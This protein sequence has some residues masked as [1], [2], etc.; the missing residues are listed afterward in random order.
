MRINI[1]YFKNM[2]ISYEIGFIAGKTYFGNQI[3][4]K[5][6]YKQYVPGKVLLVKLLE[7]YAEKGIEKIDFGSGDNHIK[8]AFTK[9]HN[10][11]YQVV[12]SANTFVRVY[13]PFLFQVKNEL[14]YK[15]QE[16]LT[17]YLAYRSMRNR[18]FGEN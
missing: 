17:I 1:L 10:Q 18:I 4:F 9:N 6:Q 15:L 2:P 3:A 5:S 8:R 13:I 12:L 16:H 14:Y 11:F 7:H